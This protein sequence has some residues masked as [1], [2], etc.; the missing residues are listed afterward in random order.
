MSDIQVADKD[1]N[2]KI[3]SGKA[4]EAFEEYYADDVVMQENSDTPFVGKDVNRKRELEFFGSVKEFHGARLEGSAVDG[5]T[6]F[7]QWWLDITF[8]NGQRAQSTQVAV[9]KWKN[10]KIVHERFFYNKG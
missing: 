6:S 5:D 7:S 3:L 4:L 1:L 9:R 2:E 10:G 8:Q